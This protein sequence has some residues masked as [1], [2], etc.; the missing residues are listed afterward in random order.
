MDVQHLPPTPA[1]SVISRSHGGFNPWRTP[2]NSWRA[3]PS[4]RA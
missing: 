3:T 4:S 2:W 1:Q